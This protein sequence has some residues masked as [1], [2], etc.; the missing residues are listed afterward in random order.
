MTKF[1]FYETH[2][3]KND[4]MK[5]SQ[6]IM[7]IKEY[8]IRFFKKPD[9]NQIYMPFSLKTFDHLEVCLFSFLTLQFYFFKIKKI[10]EYSVQI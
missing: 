9:C 2:E 10:I 6:D 7:N 1:S 3:W 5:F 8:D 4:E